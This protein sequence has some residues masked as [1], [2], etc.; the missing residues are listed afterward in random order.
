M[1]GVQV[2]H[3]LVSLGEPIQTLHHSFSLP[4]HAVIVKAPQTLAMLVV[5]G[6]R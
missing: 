5:A 3:V 6:V 4:S 2:T 1:R